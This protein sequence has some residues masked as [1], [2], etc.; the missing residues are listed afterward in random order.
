MAHLRGGAGVQVRAGGSEA[1]SPSAS[2]PAW[3]QLGWGSWEMASWSP[4]H[5]CPG[6]TSPGSPAAL[7]LGNLIFWYQ[8]SPGCLWASFRSGT[9]L[10]T[11]TPHGQCHDELCPLS[12]LAWKLRDG[13]RVDERWSPRH[14]CRTQPAGGPCAHTHIS[15]HIHT[16]AHAHTCEY[17]LCICVHAHMC[18]YL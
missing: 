13:A 8:L 3:G 7:A 10:R 15:M 4:V 9:S 14:T 18:T 17:C 1:R 16:W 5:P 11:P 2:P 6:K 12:G